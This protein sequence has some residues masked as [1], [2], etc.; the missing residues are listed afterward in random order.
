M[1]NKLV[2]AA[3]ASGTGYVGLLVAVYL[4]TFLISN[5]V[6]NNAAAALMF[7]IAAEAAEMQGESLLKIAFCVMLAASASFMSPF[8]YQTNLMVYGPGG[9]VFADFLRFGSPMQVAQL[10]VSVTV[11]ALGEEWWWTC[12]LTLSGSL[13]LVCAVMTRERNY[14]GEGVDAVARFARGAVA[15]LKKRRDGGGEGEGED[16]WEN[17][18][19]EGEPPPPTAEANDA[20]R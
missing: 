20:T 17:E 11:L 8:G 2:D 3:T 1:A 7:P 9:Y 14:C 19:E 18:E 5:V 10:I 4:A 6:T 12:W 13:A 15:K 16:G